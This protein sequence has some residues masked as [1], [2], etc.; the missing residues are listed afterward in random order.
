M[1][2]LNAVA[3]KEGSSMLNILYPKT[4]DLPKKFLNVHI[5]ALIDSVG[6]PLDTAYIATSLVKEGFIAVKMKVRAVIP[7]Y[8]YFKFFFSCQ[9]LKCRMRMLIIQ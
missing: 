3:A 2:V 6:S 7:K 8:L 5:C 1:A 9:W 4:V